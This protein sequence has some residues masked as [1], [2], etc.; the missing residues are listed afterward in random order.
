MPLDERHQLFL[1]DESRMTGR[2]ES[3]SFPQSVE[4]VQSIVRELS[5][6][7]TPITIQGSRTGI[8]GGAVPQGGH[9]LNLSK[10]NRVVGMSERVAEGSAGMSEGV[11][12]M[13]A[14][15]GRFSVRVQPGITLAELDELLSHKQFASGDWDRESL[16]ALASFKTSGRHFWP[17]DPTERSASIGGIAAND[18][19]GI[20]ARHY[21]PASLHIQ[22]IRVVDA[23]GALQ[24]VTRHSHTF[25]QITA[26]NSLPKSLQEDGEK[27]EKRESLGELV[28]QNQVTLLDIFLGS[29]GKLGAIVELT[30]TLQPLPDALWGIV[31]FFEAESSAVAFIQKVG[32][33]DGET[34]QS[35]PY[36]L[37]HASSVH[38]GGDGDMISGAGVN[39]TAIEF[40]DQVTLE[41]I[42][43]FRSVNSQLNVLPTWEP[44]FRSAV[45]LEMHGNDDEAVEIL[46]ERLLEMVDECGGDPDDTWAFCGEME[47]ER[48]HLFRHAAPESANHFID[49]VRQSDP[50]IF[51][52]GT[53]MSLQSLPLPELIGFY[54]EGLRRYGLRGAIFGHGA[55]GHLHVNILPEDYPQFLAGQALIQ[56]WTKRIEKRG[57]RVVTEHGM[58]KIKKNLFQSI[59]L[60]GEMERVHQIKPQLDP[61]GLWGPE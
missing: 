35:S 48:L 51:K 60:P 30:L 61:D 36:S 40:M 41:C 16:E 15:E 38:M 10:L 49:T 26:Q 23:N 34:L 46:S 7:G 31:F 42:E 47:I 12:G 22:G 20:C 17:P 33:Y 53:D 57:G 27:E 21:G 13:P 45:Y 55:S 50:R 1:K 43:A 25:P 19:R 54:R 39:I 14:G 37:L 3:I 58:G 18:S 24:T 32:A 6:K 2:A 11:A 9:I 56:M 29:E 4:D 59:P 52:L 8:A 5:R 28:E 44:R